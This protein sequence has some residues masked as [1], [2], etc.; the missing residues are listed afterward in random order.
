MSNPMINPMAPINTE[1]D[2]RAAARASAVAIFIGVLY[3][4]FGLVFGMDAMRAGV[5]AQ[6]ASSPQAGMT[7][8]TLVNIAV[9][10]AVVFILIQLGLGWVQWAKPNIVIPII[11]VILVAWGLV[12]MPLAMQAAANMGI[13]APQTPMWMTVLAVVVMVVELVLHITGVRGASKLDKLRKAGPVN[14]DDFL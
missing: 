1:A 2:A 12:Q 3:G 13:E 11:F 5:D 4:L 9:G 14:E 6:M 8:E 10:M 7:S